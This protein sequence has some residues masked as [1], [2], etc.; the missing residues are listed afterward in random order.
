VKVQFENVVASEVKLAGLMQICL[1][2]FRQ[3][4]VVK[5]VF[6]MSIAPEEFT[7]INDPA[8]LSARKEVNIHEETVVDA[9]DAETT[10]IKAVGEDNVKVVELQ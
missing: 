1:A 7:V 9:E 8:A 5:L 4:V 2:A 10:Q 6:E 3:F